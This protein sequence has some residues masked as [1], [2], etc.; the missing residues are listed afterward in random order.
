MIQDA[1]AASSEEPS[2]PEAHVESE[3]AEYI[4]GMSNVGRGMAKQMA[5]TIMELVMTRLLQRPP[6]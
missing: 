5:W 2:A 4:D 6:E 3:I 1:N